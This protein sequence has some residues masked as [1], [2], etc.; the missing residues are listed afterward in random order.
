MKN[1]LICC[2]ERNKLNDRVL[3]I[4][5][6][7]RR[8]RQKCDLEHMKKDKNNYEESKREE[9]AESNIEKQTKKIKRK[10]RKG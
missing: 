10:S 6:L 2:T 9:I 3:R 1:N 7:W 4:T 8:V 5:K